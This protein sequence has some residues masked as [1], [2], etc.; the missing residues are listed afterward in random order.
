MKQLSLA[1][2]IGVAA[3]ALLAGLATAFPF[4]AIFLRSPGSP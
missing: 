4:A 2:A 1:L 3:L